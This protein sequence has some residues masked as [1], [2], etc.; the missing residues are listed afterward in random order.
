MRR[1]LICVEQLGLPVSMMQ[2]SRSLVES[3]LNEGLA[4]RIS[5]DGARKPSP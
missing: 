3:A 2:V 5:S 4:V 1:K